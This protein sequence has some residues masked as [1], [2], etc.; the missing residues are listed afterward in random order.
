MPTVPIAASGAGGNELV[1]AVA[2]RKIRVLA[3]ALSFSGTTNS[4]FRT[5]TSADL[6]GL[7]YGLAGT[8]VSSPAVDFSNRG[9]FETVVGEALTLD[10]SAAVAVGGYVIY[11]LVG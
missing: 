9:H 2:T 4:K 11:E 8:Q 5:G 10:L 6:T 3:F 1:A 7:F